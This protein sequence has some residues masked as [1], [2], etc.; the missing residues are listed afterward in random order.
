MS[1]SLLSIP[2]NSAGFL[3][4]ICRSSSRPTVPHTPVI[5]TASPFQLS[6]TKYPLWMVPWPHTHCEEGSGFAQGAGR[7]HV[8]GAVDLTVGG[9]HGRAQAS[10]SDSRAHLSRCELNGHHRLRDGETAGRSERGQGRA[11][12][13]SLAHAACRHKR[14]RVQ[15]AEL[16]PQAPGT[17]NDP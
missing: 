8:A 17:P 1:V 14:R 10:D 12:Q 4:T 7:R 13:P 6:A 9:I 5:R 11:P 16:F 3:A 15:D 2:I